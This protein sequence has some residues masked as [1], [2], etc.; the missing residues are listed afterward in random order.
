MPE[1]RVVMGLNGFETTGVFV[2]GAPV[3]GPVAFIGEVLTV[4]SSGE[5][6]IS[7]HVASSEEG[8]ILTFAE[9]P[10]TGYYR[11]DTDCR[12]P[13]TITSKGIPK[14]TLGSWVWT[15]GRNC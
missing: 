6:V 10:V 12:G 8:T 11:V 5:G 1:L 4:N 3:T 15:A 13:V 9:E 14:C 2:T 7:G